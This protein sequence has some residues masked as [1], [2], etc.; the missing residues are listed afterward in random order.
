MKK[1]L[2]WSLTLINFILSLY[3]IGTNQ[4]I[5][6]LVFYTGVLLNQWMLVQGVRSMMSD[7]QNKSIL[8]I[9]KMMILILI[10]IFAMI[11]MKDFVL[12]LTI[13]YIFQLIILILSIKRYKDKN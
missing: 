8:L 9:V 12:F 6:I 1:Y 3:L 13:S 11:F 2:Y 10:F 4:M 5:Y 7:Q